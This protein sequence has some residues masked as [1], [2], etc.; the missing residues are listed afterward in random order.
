VRLPGHGPSDHERE[1]RP[2]REG[3]WKGDEKA[4]RE[5][6]AL[7]L[8]AEKRSVMVG[9]GSGISDVA[10]SEVV[11]R[12]ARAPLR[13]TAPCAHSRCVAARRG[14]RMAGRCLIRLVVETYGRCC[15]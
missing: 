15:R 13:P 5:T 8:D 1:E 12:K 2:D 4:A 7:L 9:R 3:K 14:P 6:D 10:F 11:F